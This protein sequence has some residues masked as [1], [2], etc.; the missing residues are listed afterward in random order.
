[1]AA[2]KTRDQR[3]TDR[4][5][6]STICQLEFRFLQTCTLYVDQSDTETCAYPCSL[7]HCLPEIHHFIQCPIWTCS[8]KSTTTA[9]PSPTSTASPHEPSQCS[10][11]LCISGISFN[12]VL[13]LVLAL[14]LYFLKKY[15]FRQRQQN[16]FE[17][18]L[19]NETFDAFSNE[20]I[21]RRPASRFSEH[22]PLLNVVAHGRRSSSERVLTSSPGATGNAGS[23]GSSTTSIPLT[24]TASAPILSFSPT[25][26][27]APVLRFNE[28]TF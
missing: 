12:V 4:D 10:S 1:M 28:N 21:L 3:D 8:E 23:L 20:P 18:S 16:T 15:F 25:R 24:P 13:I 2:F 14:A 17:N 9:S 19:Y 5:C 22:V 27:S 6:G 7:E 26:A 11:P